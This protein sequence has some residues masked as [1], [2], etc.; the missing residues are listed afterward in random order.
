MHQVAYAHLGSADFRREWFEG[1]IS[2]I[3]L[4]TPTHNA[5][6]DDWYWPWMWILACVANGAELFCLPGFRDEE[7]W[8][9]G[10]DFVRD[11]CDE[12]RI[13]RLSLIHRIHVLLPL[14]DEREADAPF[15]NAAPQYV[16]NN[17]RYLESAVRGF[18]NTTVRY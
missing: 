18:L 11:F 2:A 10:I 1:E 15:N 12:I 8:G 7:T 6:A 16:A 14:G 5:T 3:V 9:F 13:Q 17:R 4:F